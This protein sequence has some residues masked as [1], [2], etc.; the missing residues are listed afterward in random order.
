[1]I[2]QKLEQ[3]IS[4]AEQA[5]ASSKKW[6][7]HILPP[8]CYFNPSQKAYG[9]V[10]EIPGDKLTLIAYSPIRPA[11][12]GKKLVSLLHGKNITHGSGSL[13]TISHEIT[14]TIVERANH[15]NRSSIEWHHHMLFPDC[16][17]NTKPGLWNIVFEDPE[18]GKTLSALYD[19]EPISDLREIE[20]L[21]YAQST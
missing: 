3:V 1:M 19:T 12:A 4:A 18:T 21:F 6:H 14:R 7:F 20:A 15:L 9:L 13:A 5:H 8:V 17:L 16:A 11:E 2:E 10:V